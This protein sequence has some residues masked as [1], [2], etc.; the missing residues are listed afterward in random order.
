MR[1]RLDLE[2]IDMGAGHPYIVEI[3]A[4][5]IDGKPDV[6]VAELLHGESDHRR[7]FHRDG[8]VQ[9]TVGPVI[10]RRGRCAARQRP[11]LGDGVGDAV[12]GFTVVASGIDVRAG[13]V[14]RHRQG[15]T[16]IDGI[17]NRQ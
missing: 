6:S 14:D 16:V 12:P 17:G 8:Q 11:A 5:A 10:P 2:A 1:A 15:R 7:S 4:L 13:L 3:L 9:P